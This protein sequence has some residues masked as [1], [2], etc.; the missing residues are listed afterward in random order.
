[1]LSFTSLIVLALI[2]RLLFHFELMFMCN[3]I[4]GSNF[5][6]L[7]VEIQLSQYYLLKILFPPLRMDLAP[8]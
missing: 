3:V 7:L 8:L 1:M 6:H 4:Q 5:I 2:F